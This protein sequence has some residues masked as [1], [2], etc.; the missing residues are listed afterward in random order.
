MFVGTVVRLRVE[1]DDITK[2]Q[3]LLRL[4]GLTVAVAAFVAVG[5]YATT[6]LLGGASEEAAAEER[7][8]TLV[9]VVAPAERTLL[10]AFDGVGTVLASRSIDVRP[11]SEGRVEEVFVSSGETVAAEDAILQLDDRSERAALQQAEATRAETDSVFDRARELADGEFASDAAVE[12]AEAAFLRAEAEVDLA[13][14]ALADR[15]IAAPF[16]GV[17]GLIDIDR[18]ERVGPDTVISTLDDLSEVQVEFAVPE[19]YFARVSAGQRVA[20]TAAGD[21][22]STFDGEVSVAAPRVDAA[23]RSF[24]V[25]AVLPNPDRALAGGMF[26]QVSLVFEETE[27]MTVPDDSIISE[28]DTTYVYVVE[29]GVARRRDIGVGGRVEGSVAADGLGPDAR[30]ILTGYSRLSDGDPVEV[31]DGETGG[32]GEDGAAEDG[33]MQDGAGEAVATPA[34]TTEDNG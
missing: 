1:D 13:Q 32:A 27:A 4:G 16:D 9:T 3:S 15:R 14:K 29:E 2:W 24:A 10:D 11:L 33:V 8:P 7:P 5:A 20:I 25:R 21:G 12:A 22:E 19:R 23:S 30:V 18:G 17:L 6:A 26:V 28:G 34:A 31:A